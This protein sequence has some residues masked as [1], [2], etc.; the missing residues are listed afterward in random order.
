MNDRSNPPPPMSIEGY[1]ELLVYEREYPS[2]DHETIRRRLRVDEE[3]A[4]RARVHWAS[5]VGGDLGR[6][7]PR[8]MLALNH[9][10]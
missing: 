5:R 4:A 7:D 1:A 6:G 9:R 10:A 8:S 2:S 3:T